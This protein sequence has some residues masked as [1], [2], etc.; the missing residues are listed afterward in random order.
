MEISTELQNINQDD[1]LVSFDFNSFY[2][3]AQIDINRTWPKIKTIYPFRKCMSDAV[4]SLFNSGRWNELNRCGFSTVK[5]HIPEKLIFQR[6]P[7]REKSNNPY[8]NN[9]FEEI[10]RM[11]Y[12]IILV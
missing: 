6:L 8:K 1:W 11:R 9:R 7:V 4:C 3:S 12:S 5:Y 10:I 2:P